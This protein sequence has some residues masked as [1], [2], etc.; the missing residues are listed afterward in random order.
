[1]K[2][3][4][5]G[6]GRS[7]GSRSA[8]TTHIFLNLS[9]MREQPLYICRNF[10]N[11]NDCQENPALNLIKTIQSETCRKIHR[12][13]DVKSVATSA[14]KSVAKSAVKSA[15][16]SAAKSVRQSGIRKVLCTTIMYGSPDTQ[17]NRRK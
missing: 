13:I 9:E 10:V 8:S 4:K 14:I 16:K 11:L 5:M 2:F 1:M 12:E 6:V 7:F 3:E 17:T 15:A